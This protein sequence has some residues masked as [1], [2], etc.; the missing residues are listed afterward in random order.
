[1]KQLHPA[2][3]IYTYA[4]SHSFWSLACVLSLYR[5]LF[6]SFSLSL[7]RALSVSTFYISLSSILSAS[8]L[9]EFIFLPLWLIY[10]VVS[11]LFPPFYSHWFICSFV[12][13]F[14]MCVIMADVR[15]ICV[16]EK[17]YWI[18]QYNTSQLRLSKTTR[19]MKEIHRKTRKKTSEIRPKQN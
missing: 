11:M 2:N 10:G 3:F 8:L 4:L 13:F 16:W 14:L 7:S 15:V 9:L 17:D 1:M 5:N 12:R 6:F 19:V 18:L